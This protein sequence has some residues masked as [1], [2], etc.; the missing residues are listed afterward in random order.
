MKSLVVKNSNRYVTA[1]DIIGTDVAI[2]VSCTYV[3]T[4]YVAM[5]V[6]NVYLYTSFMLDSVHT[7]SQSFLLIPISHYD[8]VPMYVATTCVY[9]YRLTVI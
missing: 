6:H 2:H 5:Y 8:K 3:H 9:K 4:T 1:I 7:F